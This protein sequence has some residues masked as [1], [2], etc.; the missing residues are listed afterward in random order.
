[1]GCTING[2]E[3]EL[4]NRTKCASLKIWANIAYIISAKVRRIFIESASTC[5]ICKIWDNKQHATFMPICFKH[6]MLSTQKKSNQQVVTKFYLILVQFLWILIDWWA[7]NVEIEYTIVLFT[8]LY[9]Q[10]SPVIMLHHSNNADVILVL[11]HFNDDIY[12]FPNQPHSF[13]S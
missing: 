13:P 9:S 5:F 8:H 11:F 3:S 7:E 4:K 2:L 6:S 1:M 10:Q 12:F